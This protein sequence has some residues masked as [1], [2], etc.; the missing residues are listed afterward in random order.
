M[1]AKEKKQLIEWFSSHKAFGLPVTIS[2]IEKY[3]STMIVDP[4]PQPDG[5]YEE[6]CKEITRLQEK[7]DENGYDC[8]PV[9]KLKRIE[10]HFDCFIKS[11]RTPHKP[12]SK[13]MYAFAEW[14]AYNYVRLT[15]FWVHKYQNQ[16][17]KNN[18]QSTDELFKFWCKYV[19]IPSTQITGV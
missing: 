16:I 18:W 9:I 12:T 5:K 3:L 4:E 17:D 7:Y 2:D 6:L 1:T 19:N 13:D 8:S 14:V 10:S 11:N 15:D